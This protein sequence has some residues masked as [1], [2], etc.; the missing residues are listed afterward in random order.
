MQMNLLGNSP[1]NS[2]GLK[3]DNNEYDPNYQETSQLDLRNLYLFL[4]EG[5]QNLKDNHKATL[6]EGFGF[7]FKR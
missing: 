5:K 7:I 1:N 2:F 6:K 3:I 4:K